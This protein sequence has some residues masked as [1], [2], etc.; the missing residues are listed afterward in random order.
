MNFKHLRYFWATAHAGG[1]VAAGAQLHTTPQTISSQIK[2]LE[3]QLGCRLFRKSGRRLELTDQGR[4]ALRYADEIFN[5]GGELSAALRERRGAARVLEFRVGVADSVAKM[6]AYRLLL[7]ALQMRQSVQLQVH[8]GRMSELLGL[9][10]VHR[11]DMVLADEALARRLSVKAFNHRLGS[12]GVSFYATAA[13]RQKLRGPFPQCLDGAP[14]LIHGLATQFRALLG[15]WFAEQPVHPRVVGEFDDGALVKEF[16]RSGHG[17]FPGPTVLER[18][19]CAQYG[20]EVVGRAAGLE[21]EFFAISIERR[22]THPG[23]AA[24]M[25]AAREGFFHT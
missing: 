14:M 19:I 23:V 6:L 13:V 1:V 12:T 16:G 21:E 15:N 2:L 9:I 10:A 20:V 4:V 5:L 11:I 7:P 24:I 25:Q 17:V 18:E 8:E 3:E 22:V